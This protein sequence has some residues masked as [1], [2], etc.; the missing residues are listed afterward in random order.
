MNLMP[1][2]LRQRRKAT[3]YRA[4]R[5]IDYVAVCLVFCA[6]SVLTPAVLAEKLV[7]HWTFDESGP[8]FS[9]SSG[10]SATLTL[11]PLTTAPVT[12]PGIVAAG[13][14]LNWK[15]VPGTST[16]LSS[17]NAALQTDSFGFSF[18]LRPVYLDPGN[19]LIAKEMPA[20]TAVSGSQQISWQVRISQTNSNGSSPLEFVVRGNN[21]ATGNFFGNVLSAVTVPLFTNSANW[22]HVAGGYD[23]ATGSLTLFVNGLES[24]ATNSVAGAQSSDG[25]PF[26]VGSVKNGANYVADAPL[27]YLDDLQL[28]N[29][30]LTAVDVAF[31][32]ANPGCVSQSFIISNLSGPDPNG[33]MVITFNSTN[34]AIYNV[35]ASID[36][37]TFIPVATPI[38]V[39]NVTTVTIP[40][41]SL[42]ETFGPANRSELYFRVSQLII[43]NSC[44]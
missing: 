23:T 41:S 29:G 35:E 28:Y 7:A 43:S 8:P 17:T 21:P 36:L 3:G 19:N 31:L 12:G 32:M 34:T 24:E 30:P 37:S 27:I 10:N 15:Q 20:T 42:D 22:F 39:G 14:L 1:M 38:A 25:S 2:K 33:N 13:T 40:K 6:I 44:D 11:D 9:D 18:W 26:D 16:R 4:L 5:L